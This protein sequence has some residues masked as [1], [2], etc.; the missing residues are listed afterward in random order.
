MKGSMRHE[1]RF[2]LEKLGFKKQMER[3]WFSSR[4]TDEWSGFINHVVSGKSIGTFR[5]RLDIMY[6]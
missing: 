4:V 3:N 6:G 2:K 5:R 1:E